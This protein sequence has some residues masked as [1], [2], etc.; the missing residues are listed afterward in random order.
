MAGRF[1]LLAA[2]RRHSHSQETCHRQGS[3]S[4]SS[5]VTKATGEAFRPG[6]RRQE[7][8]PPQLRL[9]GPV[10]KQI[11]ILDLPPKHCRGRPARLQHGG[12]LPTETTAHA[13]RLLAL[14]SA[15]LGVSQSSAQVDCNSLAESPAVSL[16][17]FSPVSYQTAKWTF[18]FDASAATASGY[19]DCLDH[20]EFRYRNTEDYD[21]LYDKQ[22]S[23]KTWWA[24]LLLPPTQTD[25]AVTV[26]IPGLDME[27]QIRPVF[28][29]GF[30]G[31]WTSQ[32]VVAGMSPIWQAGWDAN[33]AGVGPAEDCPPTTVRFSDRYPVVSQ[34]NMSDPIAEVVVS[35]DET[36]LL[37]GST[38]RILVLKV[39]GCLLWD[40]D[41]ANDGIEL[42]A[43]KV[44]V[45]GKF[46]VGS[47][48]QPLATSATITLS[49]HRPEEADAGGETSNSFVYPADCEDGDTG[50]YSGC[51][52][53][54]SWVFEGDPS[55][56]ETTVRF[57]L[58]TADTSPSD[59][60]GKWTGIGF[61]SDSSMVNSDILACK[62]LSDGSI[63]ILDGWS[64]G[65]V[66]PEPD[67]DCVDDRSSGCQAD[68][69]LLS[70]GTEDGREFCCTVR[71]EIFT[72]DDKD[73]DLSTEMHIL[74]AKGTLDGDGELTQHT[75][76]EVT[77]K[78]L[79]SEG[80]S[81]TAAAEYYG[82]I[83]TKALIVY[84]GGTLEI[85]GRPTTS[86]TVL[87]ENARQGDTSIVVKEPVN[88]R[89]GETIRI[90][91]SGWKRRQNNGRGEP[92][93]RVVDYVEADGKTVHLTQALSNRH[94]GEI[95]TV[96]DE[97]GRE[98]GHD[99][100]TE[101]ALMQ[102]NVRIQGD[103]TS[104]T[105]GLG[106]HTLYF[107][108]ARIILRYAEFTGMGQ[109]N[110]QSRYPVHFH[111][112]GDASDCH[113][114]G[115]LIRDSLFRGLT[116]HGTQNLLVED[117]VLY[118]N[119]DK[120]IWFEEGSEEGNV[121]KNNYI[122]SGKEGIWFE[123]FNNDLIGNHIV[124]VDKCFDYRLDD[125]QPPPVDFGTFK[126]DPRLEGGDT[127]NGMIMPV[128]SR[129]VISTAT[130]PFGKN[131]DNTCHTA[132]KVYDM[133]K[134]MYSCDKDFVWN[135]GWP[136]SPMATMTFEKLTV[137]KVKIAGS[138]YWSGYHHYKNCRFSE[139]CSSLGN[140]GASKR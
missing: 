4:D 64:T 55:E 107:R 86:W 88:W 136:E 14:L 29:N 133:W 129:R 127:T 22:E 45:V 51:E 47:E 91:S 68:G 69:E 122:D 121:L 109:D 108:K 139:I 56:I 128:G 67:Y 117:S 76:S 74:F 138:G 42:T 83:G 118:K 140:G 115:I 119:K 18:G 13:M 87:D 27:G 44:L 131:V 11:W 135:C 98:F 58:C 114:Q 35:K 130:W 97:R 124:D 66:R 19:L 82:I 85:H 111:L 113:L 36:M 126:G 106:G 84:G 125:G 96:V 94:M 20:W 134:H 37:D 112:F 104:S 9:L 110:T 62:F 38:P 99:R 6:H 17:E 80:T 26:S 41:E 1:P 123:N 8:A 105:T 2:L 10:L 49:G 54:A 116:L 21:L 75:Y 103:E 137:Y 61:S 16:D 102:R 7:H 95:F 65:Y 52:Y 72:Q 59:G 101:V 34:V 46:L 24:L 40:Q 90:A 132:I 3:H 78:L 23:T 28:T 12:G 33:S 81:A 120:M 31:P 79:L 57:E 92:D 15:A 70:Y 43:D 50:V 93:V 25:Y 30:E 73:Y 53:R 39:F 77:E 5:F 32:E 89:P 48:A 100:R 71:R 63:D 60:S